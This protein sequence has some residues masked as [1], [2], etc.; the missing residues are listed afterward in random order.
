MI[1][2]AWE[3]E[4]NREIRFYR[5]RDPYGAFSNFS[6]D[7]LMLD[8]V[9]WPTVEHYY[10][11]MK[12][13]DPEFREQIRA[14]HS[15]KDAKNLARTRPMREMWNDDRIGV[16][17]TA[18]RAKFS[19][20]A[21][22]KLMLL[23]TG[24]AILVDESPWDSFWGCGS[25]GFGKNMLGLMLMDLRQ[26]LLDEE[27][28]V[29][30]REDMVSGLIS[31]KEA[32]TLSLDVVRRADASIPS[33]IGEAFIKFIIPRQEFKA[34]MDSLEIMMEAGEFDKCHR[35]AFLSM[36]F[37]IGDG[38]VEFFCNPVFNGP[39]ELLKKVCMW[40]GGCLRDT[41]RSRGVMG[42]GYDNCPSVHAAERMLYT[43]TP[44]THS[45]RN[46]VWLEVGILRDEDGEWKPWTIGDGEVYP[47]LQCL[48]AAC[49]AGIKYLVAAD[50]TRP[51]RF[52]VCDVVAHASHLMI[53]K[54]EG[55]PER[56]K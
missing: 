8:G 10:Q 47:C 19:Q 49:G 42:S 31:P 21:V 56:W 51:M 27:G 33:E 38:G 17:R 24:D 48:R 35:G 2:T 41:M 16:M 50:V 39:P 34:A 29:R 46:M 15:P 55:A 22:L 30:I 18:L 36:M 1:A 26:E 4:M 45:M 9:D 12:H 6:A 7:M 52:K 43:H 3:M 32:M 25:D 53:R 37:S 44:Y 13:D 5:V 54:T 14:C 11:A 20:H 40:P 28:H 23:L